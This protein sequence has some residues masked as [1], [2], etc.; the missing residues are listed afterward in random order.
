MTLYWLIIA[1]LLAAC[2]LSVRGAVAATA[3]GSTWWLRFHTRLGLVA[4]IA[5][6]L[7]A[8]IGAPI[9]HNL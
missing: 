6:G 4:A 2:A 8:M 1:A 9:A 7:F 3:A 5:A